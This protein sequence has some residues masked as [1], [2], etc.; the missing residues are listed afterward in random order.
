MTSTIASLTRKIATFGRDAGFLANV[1]AN[2]HTRPV[3]KLRCILALLKAGHSVRLA[4]F[5]TAALLVD[6][7][8]LDWSALSSVEAVICNVEGN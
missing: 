7:R 3:T 4:P 8:P 2:G 6:N 1:I 5:S